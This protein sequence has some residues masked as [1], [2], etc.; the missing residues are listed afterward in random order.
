MH[1]MSNTTEQ[2]S[3]STAS[4]NSTTNNSSW[5]LFTLFTPHL[6]SRGREVYPWPG[7]K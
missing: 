3:S 1:K 6:T 5:N 7:T 2:Q 4:A